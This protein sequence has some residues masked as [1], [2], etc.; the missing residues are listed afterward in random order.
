M[1]VLVSGEVFKNE[2]IF[3]NKYSNIE[4]SKNGLESAGELHELKKILPNF[5]GKKVL[6]LGCAFG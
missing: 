5:Q 6:D 1:F 2:Y 4:H 3:F